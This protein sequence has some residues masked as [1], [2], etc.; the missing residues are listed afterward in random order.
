M[1][2]IFSVISGML[3][4][5]GFICLIGLGGAT[6]DFVNYLIVGFVGAVQVILSVLIEI[7]LFGGTK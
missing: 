5:S 1:K 2:K 6:I 4:V 7:I 3:F